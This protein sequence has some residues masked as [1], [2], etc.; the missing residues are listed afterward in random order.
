MG[1]KL[2][3]RKQNNFTP[4]IAVNLFTVCGL[5]RSYQ[6]LNADA[7]AF[8]GAKLMKNADPDKYSIP[9]MVLKLILIGVRILLYVEFIIVLACI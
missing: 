1:R 5:N 6:D 2:L 4:S 7:D 8:G 9:D 3:K